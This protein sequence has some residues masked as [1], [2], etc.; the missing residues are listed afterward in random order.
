MHGCFLLLDVYKNRKFITTLC[1][2][3]LQLLNARYLKVDI[4]NL[5]KI[6]ISYQQRHDKLRVV[7]DTVVLLCYIRSMID[8][9]FNSIEVFMSCSPG[10]EKFHRSITSLN[11]EISK[12]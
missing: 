6:S 8:L 7:V 11:D 5:D 3:N 12:N 10:E 9:N 1:L 4:H 2:Q